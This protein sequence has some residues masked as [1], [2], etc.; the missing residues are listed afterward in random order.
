MACRC[1]G[2]AGQAQQIIAS[3]LVDGLALALGAMTAM[4]TLVD[5]V[6]SHGSAGFTILVMTTLNRWL[7][8]S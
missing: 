3:V 5:R 1:P 8:L 7:V 2:L 4:A 6:L